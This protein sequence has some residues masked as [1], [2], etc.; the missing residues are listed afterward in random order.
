MKKLLLL[1]VVCSATSAFAQP[2][3][4]T[5]QNGTAL[6]P[7]TWDC[8]CIPALTDNI[9]VNHTLTLD[10]DYGAVSGSLTVGAAGSIV[11]SVPT[12][13]IAV[14]GSSFVNNGTVTV[15]N[16]Y[17]SADAFTNNGTLTATNLMGINLN[18]ICNNYGTMTINDSLGIDT[19]AQLHNFGYLNPFATFNAGLLMNHLSFTGG[20]VWSTGTFDNLGGGGMSIMNLY[21]DGIFA[22]TSF[23]NV[24]ASL[25]N[26]N[27]FTNTHQIVVDVNLLNGDTINGTA[28]FTNSGIVSVGN[29]L[30]NSETINGTGGK[31]C[32]QNQTSNS[33][34]ISGT[35]D[36]CDLTG[37][38]IDLNIGTVAG[39]VTFCSNY[40]SIGITENETS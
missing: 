32:V 34:A 8:T 25:Y 14:M 24:N 19:T 23:L 28:T 1:V 22:N 12:R 39:S 36:I 2:T 9:V 31:F 38:N 21:T 3:R 20:D 10:I 18:A 35:I 13:I 33:G 4:T 7:F 37:G 15:G 6:S 16:I 29:D 5:I 26:S 11:G 40:C 30:L 27:T 17:H